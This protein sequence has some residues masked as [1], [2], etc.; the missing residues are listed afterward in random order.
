MRVEGMKALKER[1]WEEKRGNKRGETKEG[2][3]ESRNILAC[4]PGAP[5]GT[6]RERTSLCMPRQY[7][8]KATVYNRKYTCLNSHRRES[9]PLPRFQD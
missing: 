2:G 8:S 4:L 1:K 9:A 6:P 3:R 7:N 5:S